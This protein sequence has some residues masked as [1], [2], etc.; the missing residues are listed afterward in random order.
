MRNLCVR[1]GKF[2]RFVHQKGEESAN[3]APRLRIGS[4]CTT[5]EYDTVLSSRRKS[6]VRSLN[7]TDFD[8]LTLIVS[9]LIHSSQ[10]HVTQ[11]RYLL[12]YG[13]KHTPER[14]LPFNSQGECFDFLQSRQL[15][16]SVIFNFQLNS[17]QFLAEE[18]G[19]VA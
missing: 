9:A 8:A 10:V 14:S 18:R 6:F 5:V 1:V 7:S 17:R 15:T 2:F 4:V 3:I 16:S 12:S 19:S 13:N 11:S